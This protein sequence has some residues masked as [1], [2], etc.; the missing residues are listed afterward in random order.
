L[1]LLHLLQ[2]LEDEVEDE[3]EAILLFLL[4]LLQGKGEGE[5]LSLH[6]EDEAEDEV[7]VGTSLDPILRFASLRFAPLTQVS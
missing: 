1:L 3:V 4:H 5:A 2:H 7:V 6:L